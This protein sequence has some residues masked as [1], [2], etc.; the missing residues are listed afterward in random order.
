MKRQRPSS[1]TKSIRLENARAWYNERTGHI[2]L[3]WHGAPNAISTVTD[4]PGKRCHANLY[5]KLADTLRNAGAPAPLPA[6]A[7][8]G[9]SRR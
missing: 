4:Q 7:A 2:H 9:R 8:S 3:A 5:R 6:T 1:T